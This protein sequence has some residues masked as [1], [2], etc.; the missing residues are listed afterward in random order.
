MKSKVS[1][2]YLSILLAIL[3]MFSFAQAVFADYHTGAT[4]SI[5]WID[6]SGEIY[7]KQ[8]NLV[9]TSGGG[10]N[11]VSKLVNGWHIADSGN[12]LYCFMITRDGS[13]VGNGGGI[14]SYCI[15]PGIAWPQNSYVNQQQMWAQGSGYID[16]VIGRQT[17]DAGAKLTKDEL[18]TILSYVMGNGYNGRFTS[19]DQ[20]QN[21]GMYDTYGKIVATQ[22]LVWECIVGERT[23][24]FEHITPAGYGKVS[25]CMNG[26]AVE[27]QA[28]S[29][30]AQIEKK[31]KAALKCPS[32]STWDETQTDD[33]TYQ[34]VKDGDVYTLSLTDTNEVISSYDIQINVPGLSAEVNGNTITFTSSVPID[35]DVKITFKTEGAASSVLVLTH[36]GTF[37]QSNSNQDQIISMGAPTYEAKSYL[38]LASTQGEV[39]ISKTSANPDCTSNNPNYT[40]AGAVYGVYTEGD[41]AAGT[42]SNQIGTITTDENG[43]GSIVE[44]LQPGQTYY[45]KEISAPKGFLIDEKVYQVTPNGSGSAAAVV[46]SVENPINDPLT[47]TI[48]KQTANPVTNTTSLAGT[49][50]TIK[51]Y[52]ISP[53]EE[54]TIDSLAALSADRTW[55]IEVKERVNAEGKTVYDTSLTIDYIVD[56]LSDDLY[57][58]DGGNETM[59]VGWFTIQETKAADGYILDSGTITIG[60]QQIATGNA[61]IVG[62]VGYDGAITPEYLD[63]TQEATITNKQILGSV[64]V[65]KVDALNPERFLSGAVFELYKDD[66]KNG[67]VDEGEEL[68]GTLTETE[69]GVYTYVELPQGSYVLVEAEAPH[70]FYV[71]VTEYGVTIVEDGDTVNFTIE[72]EHIYGDANFDDPDVNPD[73]KWDVGISADTGEHI[74]PYL[75]IAIVLSLAFLCGGLTLPKYAREKKVKDATWI[76][77]ILMFAVLLGSATPSFASTTTTGADTQTVEIVYESYTKQDEEAIK[78]KLAEMGITNYEIISVDYEIVDQTTGKSNVKVVTDLLSKDE[79]TTYLTDENGLTATLDDVNWKEVK[80]VR[81]Y[82]SADY[83][84]ASDAPRSMTTKVKVGDREIEVTMPLKSLTEMQ[85]HK[86]HDI[87][88]KGYFLEDFEEVKL[89]D[90]SIVV[91]SVAS[92]CFEGYETKILELNKLDPKVYKLTGGKWTGETVEQN[93]KEYRVAEYT[94]TYTEDGTYF[95]ASYEEAVDGPYEYIYEAEIHYDNGV[96]EGKTLYKVKAKATVKVGFEG[97][98]K[99]TKTRTLTP[100]TI[101]IGGVGLAAVIA[102]V[103]LL[104]K[105]KKDKD[106]RDYNDI[107]SG[108]K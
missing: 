107:R 48:A 14:V 99:D 77:Y 79:I 41:V 37:S 80:R 64:T 20:F 60:G 75:W 33:N 56:S 10:Y 47:I 61:V 9:A 6:G 7:V 34:L 53:D 26:C 89:A 30:Y 42:V 2:K 73:Y 51:Y 52:A 103:V 63:I 55:V 18:I 70:H 11:G 78:A 85:G 65:H 12:N 32:F 35:E 105:K 91:V 25:D 68:F 28:R 15:E 102:L 45:V 24:D 101:A 97:Q 50:F 94:G 58:T 36:D 74:N 90:D 69:I 13:V 88:V 106:V 21:A 104:A 16:Y 31:V 67:T 22:V 84:K 71:D 96:E 17:S 29:H 76:V 57:F 39:K 46:E 92:P 62:K 8:P 86:V 108:K 59:P 38:Y 4:G 54:Q 43:Q 98:E 19:T 72:N 83:E 3:L 5:S 66:N 49:Q 95:H 81:V 100:G 87:V 27:S 44:G 40:L 1:K 23:A 82:A 93:G